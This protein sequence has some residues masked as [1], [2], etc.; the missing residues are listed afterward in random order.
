VARALNAKVSF[1]PPSLGAPEAFDG[2]VLERL[3][4]RGGMGEVYLARDTLLDREVAIKLI[5]S[6]GDE[7]ARQ[8]FFV[9][10]RAIARLEHPN[11]VG[12][13]RVGEVAGLPYFVS[14]YVRGTPLDR[15]DRPV[16]RDLA[17]RLAIDLSS[18]LATAHRRGVL[19][20]DIKPAN[21]IMSED[22]SVKI[23]DF[24]IAKLLEQRAPLPQ[25]TLPMSEPESRESATAI[26]AAPSGLAVSLDS[27]GEPIEDTGATAAASPSAFRSDGPPPAPAAAVDDLGPISI[28]RDLTRT[29]VAL[30]TPRYM[31]P[32]VWR[33]EPATYAS[34]VYSVGAMLFALCTGR[35]VFVTRDIDELRRAVLEDDPEP[36]ASLASGFDERFCAIVDRCLAREPGDRFGS[37]GELRAAFSA[38]LPGARDAVVPDGNPYRGL[39]CFEAEHKNLYFGRDSESRMV[40]DRLVADGFVLVA[41]DSGVGKSSLCRAGVA[42]RI[43]GWLGDSRTWTTVAWVPGPHPVAS[44]A[45]LLQPVLD[46]GDEGEL[47][48]TIAEDPAGV[49]RAVRARVGSQRG[50]LL[51]VDQLEELVTLADPTEAAAAAELLGWLALPAPGARVLATARGDFLSRLAQL[52]RLGELVGR[53]LFFLRPLSEERIREAIVGPAAAK[54]VTFVSAEVVDELVASTTRAGAGALPLLQFALAELWE[55]RDGDEL[56][57]ADSL[58]RLGGVH[59]ALCR[60][61][62]D[63]LAALPREDRR[64][65]RRAL[66]AMVS[67]D[68]TRARK[69][70]EELG[71]GVERA[72]AAMVR[73]RLLVARDGPDGTGYEIAHEALIAH[74]QTLRRWLSSDE[75]A[76]ALVERL[77]AAVAEWERLSRPDDLLLGQRQLDEIARLG[78]ALDGARRLFVDASRRRLRRRRWA[79]MA[80]LIAAPLVVIA[81]VLTVKLRARWALD[82]RID[83]HRR[84]ASSLLSEAT[85]LRGE[86]DEARADALAAFDR[87]DPDAEARWNVHVSLRA[88]TRARHAAA[89]QE[90]EQALV[91]DMERSDLRAAFAD[92]LLTQ[93]ELAERRGD[94]ARRDDLLGRL[95]LFDDDGS[96]RA[97]WNAP[98]TVRFDVPVALHRFEA[99]DGRLEPMRVADQVVGTELSPGSYLAVSGAVRL[100]FLAHRGEQL[101]LSLA[102]APSPPPTGFV[103]VP[104]GRFLVGSGADDVQRRDFFHAVPLHEIRTDAFLVARH[105]TTFG[106]WIAF[107]EAV[108]DEAR[109]EHRPRV[110]QGGFKGSLELQGGPGTWRLVMQP[111]TVT[112][113]A[114][115]G[116]TIRYPGRERLARHDWQRLPVVGITSADAEAYLRWLDASGRVPG[117][118]FCDEREWERVARGADGRPYPH[119]ERLRPDEANHDAT[120]GKRAPA[121]GPDAVGSHPAS[122]SPFRVQDMAGNVWEWTRSARS[123]TGFAARGGSWYFGPSSSHVADRE[124]TEASFRDMSV[125]LRVCADV[126]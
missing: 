22:G 30:G 61:A 94:V 111:T 24:G 125:G 23:L 68:G 54:N 52:P 38:L 65:A 5:A 53:A 25:G 13:Y 85:T 60:H 118:R 17:L 102:P 96:R 114:A 91:L 66:T 16:T 117:A 4:G 12:V 101:T 93:A 7:K 46:G 86:S 126:R 109:D 62:D 29:G 92:L 116:E 43:D 79:R 83:A 70:E 31:A 99:R 15:I 74:W 40:L 84:A 113:E 104:P 119:G 100:P 41:G 71:E 64:V 50:L 42:P 110:G 115:T 72:L 3:L 87:A 80:M 9:E 98:A 63:V 75:E 2:Y 89:A 32:E 103:Y 77:D 88:T 18:G 81:V 106:D 14:E 97:R 122:A 123:P 55:A 58:E 1:T 26:T 21:A 27:P 48:R 34:D 6:G 112:F 19:H 76:R 124:E 10:A 95:A 37:A 20:R 108:D 8:R 51:L 69:R 44:L 35:P 47:A 90:L 28:P 57:T 49:A 39:A 120:Y 33:G 45:A 59:G 121:M 67:A 56:I 73:G 11:V 36:L 107:L 105:E 78:V 82:A